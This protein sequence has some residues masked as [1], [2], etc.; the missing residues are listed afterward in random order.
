MQDRY[1][2]DIGDFANNGLLRWLTGMTRKATEEEQSLSGVKVVEEPHP[3]KPLRLGVVWYL[4]EPNERQR[5]NRDGQKV[6]YLCDSKICGPENR[7]YMKCDPHLYDALKKI[8]KAEGK[9]QISVV[10]RRGILPSN[11]LY[12]PDLLP[13]QAN[14]ASWHKSALKKVTKADIVFVNP[15]KGIASNRYETVGSKEHVY[16]KELESFA[17]NG[18]SL[19]IYHHPTREKDKKADAQIKDFSKYLKKELKDTNL[20]V[21]ALWFRRIQARFYFIVLQPNHENLINARLDSLLGINSPWRGHFDE[22]DLQ[23]Q[24]SC[25]P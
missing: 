20:T 19:V 9:R 21:R 12:F 23:G 6:H 25:S 15:D 18:K 11:T 3:K 1:V 16:M 2:G 10:Q 4:N 17:K 8:V 5:E 7:V 13:S 24:T 14:R 22:I